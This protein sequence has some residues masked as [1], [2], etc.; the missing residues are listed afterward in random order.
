[1]KYEVSV[2]RVVKNLRKVPHEVRAK[3]LAWAEA[4]ELEGL[5]YVRKIPG[6]HDEPL[7][8]R[9]KGQRSVRLSLKWRAIYEVS[10]SGAV[11]L[12]EVQEV[13]AHDYR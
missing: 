11:T 2:D 12:V 5:P 13:T 9:R 10:Q 8:G 3:L 7:L 4:V 1:M 6:F